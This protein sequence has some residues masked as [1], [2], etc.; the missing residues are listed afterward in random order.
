VFT[1]NPVTLNDAQITNARLIVQ[2][3]FERTADERGLIKLRVER[4]W[5]AGHADETLVLDVGRRL[6]VAAGQSY[7]VPLEPHDHGHYRIVPT[8]VPSAAP[9]VYPAT[10]RTIAQLHAILSRE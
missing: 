7:L 6:S 1:A 9:A 3:T 10:P 8:R 2:G 4:S 5:P